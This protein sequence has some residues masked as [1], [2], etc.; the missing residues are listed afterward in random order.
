MYEA[1]PPRN[2]APKHSNNKFYK[3]TAKLWMRRVVRE[4]ISEKR[5]ELALERVLMPTKRRTR[6]YATESPTVLCTLYESQ[7]VPKS[8]SLLPNVGSAKF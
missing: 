4:V 7:N 1:T 5:S 3:R 6:D 2:K 8:W